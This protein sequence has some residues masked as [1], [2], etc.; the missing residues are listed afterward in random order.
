MRSRYSAY[1]KGLVDYVV[2][3]THPENPLAGGTP[4][5]EGGPASNASTLEED[6]RATCN[7]ITWD[8]LRIL[9]TEDGAQP[10]EAFVTF[11][12]WF[13]VKGQKGQR[14]QGFH[15]QSFVERS[16]FLRE[17]GRWLY[18]DGDQDWKDP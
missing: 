5:P 1:C 14:A 9:S 16:R 4:A 18:V 10:E 17:G 7:K 15:T 2:D 13:K 6:V 8:K 3:T 11:Q 12:T